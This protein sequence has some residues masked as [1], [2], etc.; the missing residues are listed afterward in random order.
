VSNAA[1][2]KLNR[3]AAMITLDA[4]ADLAAVQEG[5]I[6]SALERMAAGDASAERDAD[7]AMAK[8]DAVLAQMGAIESEMVGAAQVRAQVAAALAA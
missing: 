1:P 6:T 4:L 7:A 3:I 5:R 8:L 2:K